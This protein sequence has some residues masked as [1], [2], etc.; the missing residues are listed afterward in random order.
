MLA[1]ARIEYVERTVILICGRVVGEVLHLEFHTETLII[2]AALEL[3]ISILFGQSL[4][5]NE[6]NRVR[7]AP[8]M[9]KSQLEPQN[10]PAPSI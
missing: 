10:L 1:K 7:K 5:E 9:M 6:G 2:L 3:L 8:V 4:Q